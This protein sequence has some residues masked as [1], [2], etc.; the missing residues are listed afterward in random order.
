[1]AIGSSRDAFAI[2]VAGKVAGSKQSFC[3]ASSQN[4]GAAG[5]SFSFHYIIMP[6]V[7]Y[8][9]SLRTNAKCDTIDVFFIRPPRFAVVV[10]KNPAFGIIINGLKKLVRR[11]RPPS[12]TGP[13]RITQTTPINRGAHA[14]LFVGIIARSL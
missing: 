14:I 11:K 1:M 2:V 12:A 4:V 3:L 10:V 13:R 9:L 7:Q 8:A 6:S 5:S